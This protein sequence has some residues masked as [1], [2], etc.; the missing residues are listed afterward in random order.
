MKFSQKYF[1]IG[2]L[3]ACLI[4]SIFARVMAAEIRLQREI[5]H[6]NALLYAHWAK[7]TPCEVYVERMKKRYTNILGG[8]QTSKGC[9]LMLNLNN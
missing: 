8:A 7:M 9:V 6:D 5:R 3:V 1:C 2:V 4:V